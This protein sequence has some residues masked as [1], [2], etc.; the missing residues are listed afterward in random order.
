MPAGMKPY[1]DYSLCVGCGACA[2]MLP[3]FFEMRG[4][5]AWVINF[6]E[7]DEKKHAE[8]VTA[9]IYGAISLEGPGPAP[10]RSHGAPTSRGRSGRR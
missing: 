6:E 8:V 4:E 1:I 5:R 7:F 10:G 3:G 2:E 9:C